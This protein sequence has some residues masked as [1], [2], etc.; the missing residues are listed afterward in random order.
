MDWCREHI[1]THR[2]QHVE[3][4]STRD[5]VIDLAVLASCHHTIIT[6]GS[7]GW[8][9][10]WLANG[11]TV[12]YKAWPRQGS[13]LDADTSHAD[14]FPPHW[15]PL[16][17]QT[18]SRFLLKTKFNDQVKL[19]IYFFSLG[20][21]VSELAVRL[22]WQPSDWMVI[23]VI[24]LWWCYYRRINM[25]M[26]MST[27]LWRHFQCDHNPHSPSIGCWLLSREVHATFSSALID[28]IGLIRAL[29]AVSLR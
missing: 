17:M 4:L 11:T 22:L 14:Y 1:P 6:V 20:R 28:I 8:W 29:C 10:A 23:F 7:Y 27:R 9:A 19:S 21:P 18:A 15:I 3:F 25:M 2:L 5:P 12:Y 24:L 26:M 13:L 16:W